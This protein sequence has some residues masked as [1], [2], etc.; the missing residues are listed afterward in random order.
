M[1]NVLARLRRWQQRERH[2]ATGGL[3]PGSTWRDVADVIGEARA[4]TL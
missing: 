2:G 3:S 1:S 4:Q